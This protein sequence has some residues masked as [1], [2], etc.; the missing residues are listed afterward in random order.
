MT[1][2]TADLK[3]P[4]NTTTCLL[5]K[6]LHYIQ[7]QTLNKSSFVVFFV[8]DWHSHCQCAVIFQYISYAT[9]KKSVSTYLSISYL[10][11]WLLKISWI[12]QKT[13]TLSLCSSQANYMIQYQLFSWIFLWEFFFIL[14]IIVIILNSTFI[15]MFS[16]D[17]V[18]KFNLHKFKFYPHIRR[19]NMHDCSLR[20]TFSARLHNS[21]IAKCRIRLSWNQFS[22]GN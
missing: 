13:S 16:S 4:K 1:T 3:R 17:E 21:V 11:V 18:W 2:Q 15:L 19:T 5:L 22:V 7:S 12:S 6:T 20:N 14:F 8:S 10:E 9:C